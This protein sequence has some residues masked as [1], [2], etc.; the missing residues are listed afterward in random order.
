M[1]LR[2]LKD[3]V[4]VITGAGQGIGRAYAH[5]FAEEGCAVVIAERAVE[6]GRAV[7]DE[8][9]KVGARAEFVETDV[10]QAES[11]RRM[12]E[13]VEARFGRLDVLV[14]NAAIFST[15]T[16][17]P[18]WE[19]SEEEW[20]AIT[21]VNLKGVWLASR[22]VFP[23]M[24]RQRHGAII[25]IASAVV[26]MGRPYYLHYVASKGAVVAMTRAMAREVGPYGIRVNAVTPGATYTEVPRATV[27][28]E[29]KQAMIAQQCIA[30]PEVPDDLVGVV[31]FLASEDSAFI[32]G[33]TINV[34]GGLI[35]H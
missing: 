27:T 4:V 20:D 28:E 23:V 26:F 25:N 6:R 2:G 33:Q 19:I 12:V 22:A 35:M 31:A 14:N 7:E 15:I 18:F 9:R 13:Q 1:G 21:A 3:K 8:L 29:Q 10:A 17:K 16:M 34:D 5:R 30:R 11:C 32:T 24:Q